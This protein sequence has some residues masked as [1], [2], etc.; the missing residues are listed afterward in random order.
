MPDGSNV[1]QYLANVM[2]KL[3]AR[4]LRDSEDDIKS[5][6]VLIEVRF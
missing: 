3:Q 2:V 4:I 6:F 5:L 1:R